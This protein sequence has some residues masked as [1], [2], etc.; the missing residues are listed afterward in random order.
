LYIIIEFR[1]SYNNGKITRE[2]KKEEKESNAEYERTINGR[3]QKVITV[4]SDIYKDIK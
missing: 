2:Y 3:E 4:V 1:L